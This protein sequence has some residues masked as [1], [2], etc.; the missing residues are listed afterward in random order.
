MS[1]GWITVFTGPFAEA[2]VVRSKLEARGIPVF[3]PGE[4]MRPL[5]PLGDFGVE[6]TLDPAV[7]VPA[8]AVEEARAWIESRDEDSAVRADEQELPANFFETDDA[9]DP[10]L[11][12][13]ARTLS[14]CI[15]WG[16]IFPLGAPF[17]LW[18]LGPYLKEV[19]RLGRKPPYHRATIVAACLSPLNF[20]PFILY[21]LMG[22]YG[23]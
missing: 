8:S 4:A 2:A 3:I 1:Q 17:A 15:I 22:S 13:R 21:T 5:A 12:A 14:R 9:V 23:R 7:Q 6:L 10:D 16:A 20:V 18:N 11:L 19:E